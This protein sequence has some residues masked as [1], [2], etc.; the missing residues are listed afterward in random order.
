MKKTLSHLFAF[1]LGLLGTGFYYRIFIWPNQITH[2]K[3]ICVDGDLGY[4]GDWVLDIFFPVIPLVLIFGIIL[5]VL[6]IKKKFLC[7]NH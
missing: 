3:N 1:F 4:P 2:L 6:A 5:G 7:Q